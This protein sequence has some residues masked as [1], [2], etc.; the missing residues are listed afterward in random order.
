MI[1]MN[2]THAQG[3][4]WLPDVRLGFGFSDHEFIHLPPTFTEPAGHEVGKGIE[5]LGAYPCR[6]LIMIFYMSQLV[7]SITV[8]VA[9]ISCQ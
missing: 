1:S 6:F 5:I 8:I 4:V 9:A 2:S 7:R 3:E